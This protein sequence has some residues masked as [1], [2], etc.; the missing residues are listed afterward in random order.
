MLISAKSHQGLNG[1]YM[2][3]YNATGQVERLTSYIMT[4]TNS[5]SG[6]AKKTTFKPGAPTSKL[7]P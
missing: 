2:G 5:T 6:T 3:Q 1:Y 7:L 4:A